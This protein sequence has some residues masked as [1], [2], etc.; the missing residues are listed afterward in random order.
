MAMLIHNESELDSMD[1]E[2]AS[3]IPFHSDVGC[4]SDAFEIPSRPYA[5]IALARNNKLGNDD[6]EEE[7]PL[8]NADDD[9][10]ANIDS[11]TKPWYHSPKNWLKLNVVF[12]LLALL[13]AGLS[14]PALLWSVLQIFL[15]WM[16]E[17]MIAGSFAFI[18]AYVACD[19]LM[20]PC[21]VFTLGAGFV[22]CNVLHSM[23]KGLCLATTI[24][25]LS[26]LI[27]ATMAFFIARYL[28]RGTIKAMAAKY[29]KF[30]LLDAAV[31]R[32]GFKVNLLFRMSPV[33]PY[34]LLN[35][36]M[37]LTSVRFMDYLLACVGILPNFFVCCLLGGSLHHIYELSQID[38]TKNIP[39]LVG[40][41]VGIVLVFALLVYGAKCIKK[42][43]D[44]ISLQ[45]KHEDK[46]SGE[47]LASEFTEFDEEKAHLTE[48]GGLG[49]GLNEV[50]NLD[51][52]SNLELVS[53]DNEASNLSNAD[54]L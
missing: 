8:K 48:H 20:L 2:L 36:F 4:L 34:N 23:V 51:E 25:F 30:V 24:V 5:H 42:E 15:R 38:I 43:L 18:G 3:Q 50:S 11:A 7:K 1:P 41:I 53:N 17:H 10:D 27:A 35:Y 21:L 54:A 40:T 31:K 39:L 13:I 47:I 19:L 26:E 49:L 29:P 45:M 33:T 12:F 46:L 37:G 32:H 28:L 14:Q 9:T 16:E 22:Y 52:I 44:K 6:D